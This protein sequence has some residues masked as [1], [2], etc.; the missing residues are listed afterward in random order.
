MTGEIKKGV[1]PLNRI[2]YA[3][4]HQIGCAISWPEGAELGM[5]GREREIG[6]K[7]DARA[8]R[9]KVSDRKKSRG[10]RRR[11]SGVANHG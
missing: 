10:K 4:C 3:E 7:E 9:P 11:R 8:P 2:G 5:I 1:E 6:K